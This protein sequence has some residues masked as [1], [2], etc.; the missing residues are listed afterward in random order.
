M[1]LF[2]L[3]ACLF[4]NVERCKWKGGIGERREGTVSG[5]GKV[6]RGEGGGER[7]IERGREGMTENGVFRGLTGQLF[8]LCVY[9]IFLTKG[10]DGVL[11]GD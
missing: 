3:F 10:N 5:R 6:R 1:Y 2:S 7:E 11:M 8:F 4:L 9:A